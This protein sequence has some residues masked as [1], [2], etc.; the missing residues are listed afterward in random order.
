MIIEGKAEVKASY[1]SNGTW[2]EEE[3]KGGMPKIF[4]IENMANTAFQ[5][6][7]TVN[8][9]SLSTLQAI[10]LGPDVLKLCMR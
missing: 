1:W 5:Q 3:E 7:S 8:D 9:I 2:R 6:R 4:C 10:H